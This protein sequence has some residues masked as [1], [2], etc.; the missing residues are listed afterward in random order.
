MAKRQL[1]SQPDI[2]RIRALTKALSNGQDYKPPFAKGEKG[3]VESLDPSFFPKV[4]K[5]YRKKLKKFWT[6]KPKNIMT[7]DELIT[8][9][10]LKIEEYKRVAKKNKQIRKDIHG[11]FYSIGAPL[12]DN[13]LR[14]NPEQRRWCMDVMKLVEDLE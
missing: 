12:N 7:K 4:T 9:Q 14:F 8:K 5:K 13:I 2:D 1:I 3:R 11:A 6:T 10:Q